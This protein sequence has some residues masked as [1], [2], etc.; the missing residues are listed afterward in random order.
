M[1]ISEFKT[2]VDALNDMH[3]EADVQF[4]HPHV[5]NGK[6]VGKMANFTGY[7]VLIGTMQRHTIRL[8]MDYADPGGK[9]DFT[10]APKNEG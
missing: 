7:K 2:M 8:Y 1:K 6:K 3:P 4:V 10:E 9:L 5:R